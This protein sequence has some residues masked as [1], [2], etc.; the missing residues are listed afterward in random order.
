MIP[1]LAEY[2]QP[3]EGIE[4]RIVAWVEEALEL[5]HGAAEDPEGGLDGVLDV[6]TP[7]AAVHQL[8]RV[9]QR[10]DRVDALLANATRA[11]AR[12]KRAEDAAKF[13]AAR[14]YDEA[15]QQVGARRVEF[16]T[17]RERHADASLNSFEQQRIAHH[18][19]R[20]VSIASEAHEVINQVHWQLDTLRKELR[21]VLNAFQ[22]EASMD[23]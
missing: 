20:T 12:A 13:Q 7:V 18:A 11:R 15:A 10:A 3:F 14:A 22:F 21:A 19:A 23:R 5:R 4:E 2:D 1:E 9:V 6:D 17:A 16:S 8:R